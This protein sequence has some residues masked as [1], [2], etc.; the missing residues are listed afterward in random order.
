MIYVNTKIPCHYSISTHKSLELAEAN[1]KTNINYNLTRITQPSHTA[2]MGY[3]NQT[4]HPICYIFAYSRTS[5]D[6]SYRP[7]VQPLCAALI[8][9]A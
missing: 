2:D 6:S 8:R 4:K 1:N 9:L 7:Y 3:N 5:T